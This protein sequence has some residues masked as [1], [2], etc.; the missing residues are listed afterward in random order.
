[1]KKTIF[2]CDVCGK[3]MVTS[4]GEVSVSHSQTTFPQLNLKDLC[5]DCTRKIALNTLRFIQQIQKEGV[6]DV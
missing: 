1:M 2:V 4:W 6:V 3:E 5:F